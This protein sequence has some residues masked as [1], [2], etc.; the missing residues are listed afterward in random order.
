MP[1][2]AKL[3]HLLG[4]TESFSAVTSGQK[5]TTC[6]DTPSSNFK[7]P[8]WYFLYSTR[9]SNNL[10][11]CS[12]YDSNVGFCGVKKI[13]DYPWE[14]APYD[15]PIAML[16]KIVCGIQI[17]EPRYFIGRLRANLKWSHSVESVH[18]R[19]LYLSSS[20]SYCICLHEPFLSEIPIAYICMCFIRDSKDL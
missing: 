19:V 4:G 16:A 10:F 8:R 6:H 1:N 9:W 15:I 12:L 18:C 11:G 2:P 7:R 20:Q 17:L 3:A 13:N 5:R 14:N